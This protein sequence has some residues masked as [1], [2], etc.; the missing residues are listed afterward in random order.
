V[1]AKRVE[2]RHSRGFVHVL[3][4][5]E[6]F[7]FLSDFGVDFLTGGYPWSLPGGWG[8]QVGSQVDF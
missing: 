3:E 7:S 8:D 5:V 4:A 1:F 6:K 2:G